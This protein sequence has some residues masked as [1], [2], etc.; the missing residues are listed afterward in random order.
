MMMTIRRG[1]ERGHF[2]HGWLDT[3]H[4]FS[5]ADYYDENHMGF[6][7]LRVINED[8]VAPG[9]GFGT[10]PHRDMEIITYVLEGAL[11]HKDSSGG[12]G[13]LRPGE[14]Q[15]M[16]AG[17]GIRHSEFNASEVEPVHLL[18]IWLLPDKKGL[19]PG[20]DQKRFEI[21]GLRLVASHDG[22]DGSLQIHQ[23]VDLFA[24][25]LPKG[26]EV[27]HASAAGRH[28]WLQVARGGVALNGTAL[29]AGDGA[30]VSDEREL[31]IRADEPSEF[32]LFDLA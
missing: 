27:K 8:R 12:E 21:D 10:H 31:V 3:Y 30:A 26:K 25:R 19:K 22:R 4:T 18:Q 9:Q 1:D 6:R 28:A 13:V 23:D 2:N 20:Y 32:L 5:F 17:A 16:T 29:R 7:A 15:H 24:A 14:V 11:A